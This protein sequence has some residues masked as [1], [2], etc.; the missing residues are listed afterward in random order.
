MAAVTKENEENEA[1]PSDD[2]SEPKSFKNKDKGK[3]KGDST[4]PDKHDVRPVEAARQI[5]PRTGPGLFTIYK[6]GQGYWTR[7]GTLLAVTVLGLMLSY[8][9]LAQIQ[10]SFFPQDPATGKTVGLWVAVGFL[11]VYAL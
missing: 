2:E 8:T 3:G 6:K 9:L 7:M 10:P 1:D 11:A 5:E 4:P